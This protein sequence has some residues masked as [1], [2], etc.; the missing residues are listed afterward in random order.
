MKNKEINFRRLRITR[1]VVS[2]E[3][4]K[5]ISDDLGV[6]PSRVGQIYIV[7][8]RIARKFVNF[9][10]DKYSDL[11][12]SNVRERKCEWIAAIDKAIKNLSGDL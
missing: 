11:H 7:G 3:T 10:L 1:R 2:G 5:S 9:E 6:L 8:I 12:V 4:Y